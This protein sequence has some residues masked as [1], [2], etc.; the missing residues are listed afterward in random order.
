MSNNINYSE[1]SQKLTKK[2]KNKKEKGIFFT[3][4][5]TI[6]KIIN[7]LKKYTFKT[8]LEP[9]CGS[10]QFIERINDNFK[11]VRITGIELEKEIYDNINHFK[12]KNNIINDDYLKRKITNRYDLIV[13]NPPFLI[14][15]KKDVINKDDCILFDGR[16]NVFI[17][18][19]IKSLNLL[20]KNGIISFVLPSSFLN[21][22]YYNKL[23]KEIYKNYKIIDII[24]CSDDE[25]ID[26][27]QNTIIFII[28][29]NDKDNIKNNLNFT[30]K[31]IMTNDFYMFNT[32]ENIKKIHSL[33]KNTKTINDLDFD[34]KVGTVVWN[35]CKDILSNNKTKT[36]L[37]Y[38]SDIKDNK[39]SIVK[40]KDEKKKNY[41]NKKGICEKMIVLNRGYGKNKYKLQFCLIDTKKEYLIENHLI[42]IICKKNDITLSNKLYNQIIKSFENPKTKEFIDLYSGNNA[43]NTTELKYILPIY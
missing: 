2:I 5:C 43:L 15:K 8:I 6:D 16:P 12:K 42:C 25:Y 20:N 21:T 14:I 4:Y 28:Q 7:I 3:P 29:K 39:L 38:S 23:R 1:L 37:I 18:F 9:S 40:Y 11:D 26:T 19:I 24:D 30:M 31:Q 36:R 22:I 41:I 10:G 35:Q 34:V 32:K 17:L 33:I 27:Q 13:G